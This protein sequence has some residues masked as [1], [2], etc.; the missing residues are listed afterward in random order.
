ML[1]WYDQ[2]NSNNNLCINNYPPHIRQWAHQNVI[3]NQIKEK[4]YNTELQS[5]QVL[6]S[7]YE[8]NYNMDCKEN[9]KLE[10][11]YI[12]AGNPVFLILTSS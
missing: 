6:D 3:C 4:L 12:F 5:S 1:K 10:M 9:S 11:E 2:T 8:M 7:T